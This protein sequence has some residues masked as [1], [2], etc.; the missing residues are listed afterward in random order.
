MAGARG[1][2][3]ECG[4]IFALGKGV[5]Q[6]DKQAMAWYLKAAQQ[7]DAQAQHNA[8]CNFDRGLGGVAVD[9]K[10]AFDLYL[11]AAD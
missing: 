10:A 11:M 2:P 9:H 8:G 4:G 7:G 6:D 5:V 1:C 3:V